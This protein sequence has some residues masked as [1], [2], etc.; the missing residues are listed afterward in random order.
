M[1]QSQAMS[2]FARSG[3][4]A[5][6]RVALFI[7]VWILPSLSQAAEYIVAPDGSDA[8]A[9]TLNQP[10]KTIQKAADVMQPGDVC[11]VR[12][13]T[14][15]E[16]VKPVRGGTSEAQRIVYRAAQG[17]KVVIKG[18]ERI[19]SWVRQTGKAW[20]NVWRVELP[21]SFFGSFNP[22]KKNLEGGWLNYGKE[23][24][25]GAVYLDGESFAEKLALAEVSAAARTF[26]IADAPDKTIL[27]VNFDG[28]D[29]N[30]A[31]AE[32][33]VRECVFFPLIKGLRFITVD[34]FTMMHA[35]ANWVCFRAFQHALLGTYYGK[36]W[37][38]QN[39]R[40]SDARCAGMVCGNDPSQEDEGFDIEATGHHL[41]RNNLIERCGEA[42]IHGFKGWVASVIENNLI[43]DI[44]TRNEFGGY[45]TGGIKLHDAVDVTVRNNVVRRV[46][47]G[48][49]EFVG[50][51]ID[52]GAQGT[53]VT[54]NVVYDMTAWALHIQNS[55]GGPILV[56]NNV[57]SGRV[58]CTSENAV[59]VHNLFADCEQSS[60]IENFKAVYWEPHSAKPVA[61]TQLSRQNNRYFNNIFVRQGMDQISEAPGYQADWNF[62]FQGARKS[63]WGD[64]SH[65]VEADFNAD[66]QFK[67]LENGVEV[68]FRADR[69]PYDVK[70]P[71]ITRDFIGVFP[72]TKQWLENH[73]GSPLTVDRDLIGNRRSNRNPA[74]GP[75]ERLNSG[76]N[77]VRLIVGSLR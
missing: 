42:G 8:A 73:D 28:A 31:F 30:T 14:Y 10:F 60:A 70:C 33:N 11:T 24:H 26:Y 38:V 57:F 59:F 2:P 58:R 47:K 6:I 76:A 5:G 22:Y 35:A 16:W 43:Q 40:I 74:A 27:Y 67:T 12:A 21:D 52:W 64:A 53:R 51:W 45:E 44:N 68:S 7:A 17:E 72:L 56:D 34:G 50:I 32:I 15:R 46:N 19:T 29:P 71:L 37:I 54:G 62:F 18:S 1:I 3:L 63:I 55:H 25:L 39:N 9:G 77:T 49:G 23:Y 41:V 20:E 65:S 4:R 75:V 66:V 48:R 36:H 61:V 69:A 13:G